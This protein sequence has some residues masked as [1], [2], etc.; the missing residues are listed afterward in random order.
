M[1][2]ITAQEALKII[3]NGLAHKSLRLSQ[4]EHLVLLECWKV[5]NDHINPKE[6]KEFETIKE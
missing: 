3:G 4:K 5:L 1:N 2:Q 6:I